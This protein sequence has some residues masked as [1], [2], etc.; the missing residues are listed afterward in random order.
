M[1]DQAN[2]QVPAG[3]GQNATGEVPPKTEETVAVS[4]A[5]LEQ[6]RAAQAQVEATRA[7]M[8]ELG[9]DADKFPDLASG[10]DA[11]SIVA[12]EKLL[13]S[14]NTATPPASTPPKPANP[15]AAP[16]TAAQPADNAELK[17]AMAMSQNAFISSQFATFAYDQLSKPDGE[18]VKIPQAELMA[19]LK[20]PDAPIIARLMENDVGGKRFGGNVFNAAVHVIRLTKPDTPAP[21]G[22]QTTPAPTQPPNNAAVSA[23]EA[24]ASASAGAS[25]PGSGTQEVKE[26]SWQ[27][28]LPETKYEPP[29]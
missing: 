2:G 20:G 22:K 7:K 28:V 19:A 12:G 29:K 14:E 9:M 18:R 6:L 17:Q 5:E 10:F 27:D 26:I 23:A 1:T 11:L 21:A 3:N 13:A 15:P 16:A 25:V 4:A 8:E 24:T